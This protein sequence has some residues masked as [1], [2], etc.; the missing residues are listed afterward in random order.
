[1]EALPSSDHQVALRPSH[2]HLDEIQVGSGATVTRVPVVMAAEL[3]REG[4]VPGALVLV[5]GRVSGGGPII[6]SL[7]RARLALG[8]TLCRAIE[9]VES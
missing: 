6:V 5:G 2:K 1:M 8:R 3:A 9:V 4:L 7:G